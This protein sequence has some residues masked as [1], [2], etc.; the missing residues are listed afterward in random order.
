MV[1]LVW[2]TLESEIRDRRPGDPIIRVIRAKVPGGWLVKTSVG[3]S[4]PGTIYL[5]D[6]NHEWK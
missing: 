2:E 3:E 1:K 4:L 5:P 6:P